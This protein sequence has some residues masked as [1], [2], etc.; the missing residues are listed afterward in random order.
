MARAGRALVIQVARELTSWM[1]SQPLMRIWNEQLRTCRFFPSV[2]NIIVDKVFTMQASVRPAC[3]SF[4]TADGQ[5]D[6]D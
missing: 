3:I 1:P 5:F 4:C 2:F 6:S